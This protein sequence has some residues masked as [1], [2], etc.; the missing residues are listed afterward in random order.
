MRLKSK[1]LSTRTWTKRN[2]FNL[3][4]QSKAQERKKCI[5]IAAALDNSCLFFF[6]PLTH[7]S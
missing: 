2:R 1:I 4:K 6:F 7:E 3:R 5:E